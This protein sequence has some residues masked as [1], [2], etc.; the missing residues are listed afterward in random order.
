MV[1]QKYRITKDT[2]YEL[3]FDKPVE[4]MAVQVLL[5]SKYDSQPN[6]RV[7]YSFAPVDGG[8]KIFA[9][10]AVITNPGSAF[11]RRTDVDGGHDSVAV[12]SLLDRIKEDLERPAGA[13]KK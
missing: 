4:N 7:S 8:T 11:E 5:G 9:D 1:T 13:K 12:Q 6:A 10:M 3:S 2:P